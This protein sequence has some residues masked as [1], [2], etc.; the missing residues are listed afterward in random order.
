MNLIKCRLLFAKIIPMVFNKHNLITSITVDGE[1]YA[2]VADCVA[3]FIKS[4]PDEEYPAQTIPFNV[5]KKK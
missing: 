4:L 3:S 5:D 2:K 1:N